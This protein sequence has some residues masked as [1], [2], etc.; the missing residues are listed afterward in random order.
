MSCEKVN[1]G[2]TFHVGLWGFQLKARYI[3]VDTLDHLF[4]K[5][6]PNPKVFN[7]WKETLIFIFMNKLHFS[8]KN[9]D[10]AQTFT[11]NTEPRTLVL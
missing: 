7:R 2:F 6:G 1:I 11:Y 9:K 5:K 8:I 10:Y 4:L 3:V